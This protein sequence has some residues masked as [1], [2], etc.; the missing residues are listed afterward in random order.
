MTH[1]C[2]EFY[3]TLQLLFHLL[4]VHSRVASGWGSYEHYQI[5]FAKE[6][7]NIDGERETFDSLM[8]LVEHYKK[9]PGI[10]VPRLLMPVNMGELLKCLVEP[11]DF[12]KRT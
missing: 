7:F 10:M 11:G 9:C 12:S 4:C 8:K 5:K 3:F 1:F 2:T 6:Q